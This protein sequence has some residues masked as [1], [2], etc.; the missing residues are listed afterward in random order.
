MQQVIPDA[1]WLDILAA[2]VN[3]GGP[4]D[5]AQLKLYSN[6]INPSR[7]TALSDLT[8]AT[9]HGYVGASVTWD[10]VHTDPT[11]GPVVT[12]ASHL[13]EATSPL[14]GPETIYGAFLTSSDSLKLLAACR[15]D[16]AV[17]ISAVGQGLVVVAEY[18][19][20]GKWLML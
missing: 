14:A 6:A 17:V 4:L 11:N 13:F 15:F 9:F 2:L 16:N 8:E 10:P 18:G 7:L 19:P 3:T 1:A 5:G 20:F 12:G